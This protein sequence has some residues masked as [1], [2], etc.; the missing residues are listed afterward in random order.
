MSNTTTL[1]EV[2]NILSYH[3]D[4]TIEDIEPTD[5]I[6]EDLEADSLDCLEILMHVEDK[7]DITIT[8]EEGETIKTVEDL[9]KMI[10][11]KKCSS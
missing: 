1:D 11:D 6:R 3:L 10:E 2:K 7:I 4:K 8:D 9:V 5:N